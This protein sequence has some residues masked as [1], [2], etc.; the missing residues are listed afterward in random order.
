MRKAE[1]YINIS[2]LAFKSKIL[3]F[4]VIEEWIKQAQE[5]AVRETVKE[6][7]ENTKLNHLYYNEWDHKMTYLKLKNSGFPRCDQDGYQYGVDIL[8]IDKNSILSIAD[9][10]IKEL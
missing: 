8:E 3:Q 7:A 2:K 10:L 4:N 1:T 5:E 6:C 9:K